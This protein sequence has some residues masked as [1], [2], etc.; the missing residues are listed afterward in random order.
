MSRDSS[1]TLVCVFVKSTE[2][3]L[4]NLT[5]M[6]QVVRGSLT[7][8]TFCNNLINPSHVSNFTLSSYWDT[9]LKIDVHVEGQ[10]RIF[11]KDFLSEN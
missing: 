3:R 1:A 4:Y 6:L 10:I 7:H 8:Q 11:S 2:S 5:R 9:K